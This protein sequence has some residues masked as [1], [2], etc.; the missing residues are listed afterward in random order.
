MK[1]L[2]VTAFFTPVMGGSA[3]VPYQLSA[4]LIKKHH[5]VT[6]YTSNYKQNNDYINS[7]PA[8]TV[9]SFNTYLNVTGFLI[10]P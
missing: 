9:R 1:I 4:T 2:Q 8:G 5:Q 6:V 3:E 7:L 10:T